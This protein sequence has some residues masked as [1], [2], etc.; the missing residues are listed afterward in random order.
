MINVCHVRSEYEKIFAFDPAQQ[1]AK[2]II[3][4]DCANAYSSVISITAGSADKS[5]RLHLAYIRDNSPTNILAFCDAIFN[6]SDVGTKLGANAG[7]W[8]RFLISNVFRVS[9][10]GRKASPALSRAAEEK[11]NARQSNHLWRLRCGFV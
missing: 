8:G 7:N 9:I 11:F 4:T 10:L 1:R 6:L 3:F 2:S 5:M